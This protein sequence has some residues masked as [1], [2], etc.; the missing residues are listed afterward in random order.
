MVPPFFII[1]IDMVHIGQ[2]IQE[3]IRKQERTVSWFAQQLFC[4]RSNVYK[5]FKKESIDSA[6][7]VRIS[8]ILKR[9]FFQLYSEDIYR[10]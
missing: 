8:I 2:V 4:D 7:L 9:D 6:L 5:I 3:E 1:R 10:K